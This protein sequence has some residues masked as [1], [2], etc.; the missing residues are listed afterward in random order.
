MHH[1]IKIGLIGTGWMGKAHTIAFHNAKCPAITQ[2][3][4]GIYPLN[5]R[6]PSGSSRNFRGEIPIR[7]VKAP[8]KLH[9]DR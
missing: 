8:V 6:Y 2:P 9:S 3:G 4:I 5:F 1:E 7:S